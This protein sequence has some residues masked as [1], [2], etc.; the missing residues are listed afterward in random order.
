MSHGNKKRETANVRA[1]FIK[2][3]VRTKLEE[4]RESG[5]G[6]IG[7]LVTAK[8]TGKVERGQTAQSIRV[9]AGGSVVSASR[10][11]K[12]IGDVEVHMLEGGKSTHLLVHGQWRR[13]MRVHQ[14][15]VEGRGEMGRCTH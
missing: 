5:Y 4:Q 9:D 7:D 2:V 11:H 6:R 1:K 12:R 14:S 10:V 13:W 3:T 8:R 15:L